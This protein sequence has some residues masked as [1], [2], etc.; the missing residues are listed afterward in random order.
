MT[1]RLPRAGRGEQPHE[2]QMPRRAAGRGRE[3]DPPAGRCVPAEAGDPASLFYAA[4][5]LR[6]AVF[7]R[8]AAAGLGYQIVPDRF[9]STSEV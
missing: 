6:E 9:P 8:A 2:P 7:T 4:V 1:F 3:F 5:Q